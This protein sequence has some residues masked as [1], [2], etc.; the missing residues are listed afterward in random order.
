MILS[1]GAKGEGEFLYAGHPPRT[2]GMVVRHRPRRARNRLGFTC[3]IRLSFTPG[4]PGSREFE[5]A[6]GEGY[7]VAPAFRCPTCRQRFV[8]ERSSLLPR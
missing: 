8:I 3:E 4:A 7:R 5:D 6:P 1:L 2:V